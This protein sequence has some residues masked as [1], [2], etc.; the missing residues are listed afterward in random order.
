LPA[1]GVLLGK[2]AT[3]VYVERY[4]LPAVAGL[5]LLVAYAACRRAEGRP[6]LGGLLA[7]LFFGWFL[8]AWQSQAGKLSGR[9]PALE[10]QCRRLS[11]LQENDQPIAIAHPHVFLQLVHYGPPE[12]APRLHYLASK[13]AS[14]RFIGNDT[15]DRAL[16]GLSTLTPLPVIDYDQFVADQ[17]SFLV[18]GADRWLTRALEADGATLEVLEEREGRI[19]FA[20]HFPQAPPRTNTDKADRR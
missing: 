3:G 12:L 11:D 15:S 2:L 4:G 6:L 14:V 7:I 1:F 8:A 20:T 17:R 5:S 10:D 19:L 13:S 16:L 18:Y 9:M